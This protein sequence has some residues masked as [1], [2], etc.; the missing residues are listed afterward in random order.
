MRRQY[1]GHRLALMTVLILGALSLLSIRLEGQERRAGPESGVSREKW[2]LELTSELIPG[3]ERA[4]NDVTGLAEQVADLSPAQREHILQLALQ[5]EEEKARML[6]ELNEAYADRVREVLTDRQRE[7]YD[8][9][10][11]VLTEL[12]AETVAAREEFLAAAGQEA[13]PRAVMRSRRMGVIDPTDFLALDEQTRGE[14]ERLRG[15]MQRSLH[16]ALQQRMNREAGNDPEAWQERRERFR[17]A[18]KRARDEFRQQRDAILSPEQRTRLAQ[19][20]AAAGP[21]NRRIREA[22]RAATVRLVE[23]LQRPAA[24]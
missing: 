4:L 12:S 11:A 13:S 18:Q 8:G 17:Q 6:R 9:V 24:Q 10:L 7:L 2:A 16:D 5:Q 1:G 14:L 20:E 15:R 19:I 23:L 21:F 3:F 22:R